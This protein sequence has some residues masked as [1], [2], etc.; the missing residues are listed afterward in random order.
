METPPHITLYCPACGRCYDPAGGLLGCPHR[1]P[2]AEHTLTRLTAFG[3]SARAAAENLR[4]SWQAGPA[5]PFRLFSAGFASRALLGRR[6]YERV[7]DELDGRLQEMEGTGFRVTPLVEGRRLAQALERSGRLLI[8]NET[9]NVSGSHKGRHL[10][11]SLL[12]LEAIRRRHPQAPRPV[13]AIYSCGNAALGAA[14]V[15]RAGGFDLHAFVPEEVDPLVEDL[16]Q[17]RGAHVHKYGRDAEAAG[18]PCYLAFRRAVEQ[19]GWLPFSCSGNDNWSNIEGGETLGWETLMQVAENGPEVT[20]AVIQVGGGALARAVAQAW[21]TAL[22]LGLL[23]RPPRIYAC[24]PEGGFPFVRAYLLLLGRIA[25]VNGLAWDLPRWDH[26][27]AP[28]PQLARLKD[29]SR[30]QASRIRRTADFARRRFGT[31][32]VGRVLEEA[33]AH[34]DAFMWAW[35]GAAPRS[36]AH[37][38]LDDETYDWLELAAAIL[39]TGG[40]AEIIDETQIARAHG[41]ACAQTDMTPC[42]TGTSGLA[43]LLQLTAT[44]D[45]DPA[46]NVVLFFTGLDRG[47]A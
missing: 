31:P 19:E 26:G 32:A 1:R 10:M 22:A 40:R 15:A 6:G 43:G 14:A 5:N 30:S 41:L 36:L 27:S 39:R 9:V 12:Y 34:R 2:G 45:I 21:R 17:R 16:L 20:A 33:A 13:L 24:Q 4:R 35:D 29:F 8:K 3:P 7:L 47:A 38:I 42:A 28:G 23:Q 46:E 44:G 18:D 25:E 37:G 11:G